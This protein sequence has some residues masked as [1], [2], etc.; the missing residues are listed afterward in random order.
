MADVAV[1]QIPHINLLRRIFWLDWKEPDANALL[2]AVLII[3]EW[4]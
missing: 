3:Q 1:V 4:N 2:V